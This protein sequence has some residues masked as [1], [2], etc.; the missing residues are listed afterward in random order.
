MNNSYCHFGAPHLG[1]GVCIVELAVPAVTAPIS[2]VII[3]VVLVVVVVV[4]VVVVIFV[5][6]VVVDL[7][8]LLLDSQSS[9]PTSNNSV[10]IL[11]FPRGARTA[12]PIRLGETAP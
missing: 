9:F 8:P 10:A 11:A 3:V 7:W 5:V 12:T 6:V 2:A 4:V 1:R